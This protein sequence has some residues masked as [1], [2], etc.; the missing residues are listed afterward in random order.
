MSKPSSSSV[1]DAAL[2]QRWIETAGRADL[3]AELDRWPEAA[4][5]EALRVRFRVDVA[6]FAA[7]CFPELTRLPYN[8]AHLWMLDDIGS[9][10]AWE[11]RI[12]EDRPEWA[13][14]IEAPR[15]LAK[16]TITKLIILHRI[17]YR[18]ERYIIWGG[19][20]QPEA[21]K[22]TRHLASL[23]AVPPPLFASLYGP[24]KVSGEVFDWRVSVRGGRPIQVSTRSV[25]GGKFRGSNMDG[26]RPTAILLDD[27][28]SP[29][30]V[31]NPELRNELSEFIGSDIR[32]SG[33]PEGGLLFIEVGTRLHRDSQ[34]ARQAADPAFISQRYQAVIAWPERADLWERCRR[35]WADLTDENR[36]QTALDFYEEHQEEMD[37]GAEVLDPHKQPIYTLYTILWSRGAVAFWKDLMNAPRAGGENTFD[38]DSYPR[39]R[40]DELR[41][42]IIAADG[43][44]VPLH[45]CRLV[46]WLDPRA[47]R[48]ATKNDY[49]AIAVLAMDRYRYRYALYVDQRRDSPSAQ[50]ERLWRWF[51]R[52]A[53]AEVYYEDN[54]FQALL[55]DAF[56]R[57]CEA[58]RAA[59]LRVDMSPQGMTSTENK[60]DVIA[61]IEP[62]L[63][64][65]WLQLEARL[66][67][68]TC[69]Q[70]REHP[71]A[72]HD[73]GLEAIAK[74]DRQLRG[75]AGYADFYQGLGL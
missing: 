72:S 7:L 38:L 37:R 57:D 14:N 31:R 35:L 51:E 45:E 9:V 49:G 43:R 58:R 47:S 71:S 39:C 52:F 21:K 74:A 61:A 27:V 44:E 73:D 50:R 69:D 13:F 8:R 33:P 65:G 41:R 5:R 68:I 4:Q 3:I 60:D 19:P 12:L 17:V 66:D 67:A 42:I 28:E 24:F 40:F 70:I 32:N 15:G 62:D 6:W 2:L 55:G 18:C 22:E 25:P 56:A 16:T 54:G 10:P 75:S 23:F 20:S 63:A 11:A 29:K 64:N 1:E 48:S 34:T 59:G 46:I 53:D 30:A 26:Q 36:L